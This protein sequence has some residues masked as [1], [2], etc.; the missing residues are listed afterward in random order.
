MIGGQKRKILLL[1]IRRCRYGGKY[2]KS[3][4]VLEYCFQSVLCR[5]NTESGAFLK[6]PM[7]LWIS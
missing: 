6:V 5:Q 7:S 2:G 3:K 1:L 4:R